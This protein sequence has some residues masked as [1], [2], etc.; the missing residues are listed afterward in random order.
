[1]LLFENLAANEA[2]RKAEPSVIAISFEII[3]RDR[4]TGGIEAAARKA[5]GFHKGHE[6]RAIV[7]AERL[8]R[9]RRP[10]LFD[11]ISGL[12]DEKTE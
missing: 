1:M 3:S 11:F 6:V 10:G 12:L 7:A 9:D 5:S 8:R 2:E 4:H